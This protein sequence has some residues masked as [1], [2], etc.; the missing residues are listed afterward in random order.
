MHQKFIYQ[1]SEEVR[2]EKVIPKLKAEVW[3]PDS[4]KTVGFPHP[5]AYKA[6]TQP[7]WQN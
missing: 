5:W 1:E 4:S 7:C 3:Y 6:C 2:G